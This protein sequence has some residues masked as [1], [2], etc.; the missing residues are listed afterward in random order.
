MDIGTQKILKPTNIEKVISAEE[1][2]D[3][4]KIS[5]AQDTLNDVPDDQEATVQKPANDELQ[6]IAYEFTTYMLTRPD[7]KAY[8]SEADKHVYHKYPPA[9]D[10]LTRY[11]KLKGLVSQ[12]PPYIF[13]KTNSNKQLHF[14]GLY[15]NIFS[16]LLR[17]VN[18]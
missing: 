10:V 1:P 5:A 7:K 6:L 16:F 11:G 13:L 15:E 4:Q 8:S 9:R 18:T 3:L 17:T 2:N 14:Y 12:C